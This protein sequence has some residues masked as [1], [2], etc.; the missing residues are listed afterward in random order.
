M[1]EDVPLIVC[2]APG[3]GQRFVR[4][5]RGPV[6][7]SSTSLCATLTYVTCYVSVVCLRIG[8]HFVRGL[9]VWGRPCRVSVSVCRP[10]S[11]LALGGATRERVEDGGEDGGPA[12]GRRTAGGGTADQQLRARPSPRAGALSVAILQL[13]REQP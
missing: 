7:R 11:V 6:A 1:H 3:G 9:R 13:D 10:S 2:G 4:A 8:T 12:T 5:C